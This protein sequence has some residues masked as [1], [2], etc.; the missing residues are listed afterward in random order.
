MIPVR[1]LSI[2][3]A[4]SVHT[5]VTHPALVVVAVAAALTSSALGARPLHQHALLGGWPLDPPHLSGFTEE[6]RGHVQVGGWGPSGA[7]G[8]GC[9]WRQVGSQLVD[10]AHW[11]RGEGCPAEW[12]GGCGRGC[13]GEGCGPGSGGRAEGRGRGWACKGEG[14]EIASSLVQGPW[15]SFLFLPYWTKVPWAHWVRKQMPCAQVATEGCQ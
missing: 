7:G 1:Q 5:P 3:E 9:G 6:L 14:M 15:P 10:G 8:G 12:G 2:R 11:V 13:A 4:A